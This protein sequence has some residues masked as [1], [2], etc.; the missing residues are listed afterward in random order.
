MIE[1]L[2]RQRPERAKVLAER[3]QARFMTMMLVALLDALLHLCEDADIGMTEAID[4]LLR[5]TDNEQSIL[6]QKAVRAGAGDPG[7]NLPLQIVRVLKL[8]DEQVAV[9]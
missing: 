4:R 9:A 3:D 1:Q 2:Q 7:D 5:I 6:V 8:I